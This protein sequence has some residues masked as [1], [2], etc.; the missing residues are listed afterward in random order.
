MKIIFSN[1]RNISKKNIKKIDDILK[2]EEKQHQQIVKKQIKKGGAIDDDIC[3]S[4]LRPNEE[5]KRLAYTFLEHI[6]QI[7]INKIGHDAPQGEGS[8]TATL[9]LETG[10]VIGTFHVR[11]VLDGYRNPKLILCVYDIDGNDLI[12]I[13]SFV[14]SYIHITIDNNRIYYLH[15]PE[16]Q[17]GWNCL[18]QIVT[19]IKNY[20]ETNPSYFNGD[21]QWSFLIRNLGMRNIINRIELLLQSLITLENTFNP[22]IPISTTSVPKSLSSKKRKLEDSSSKQPSPPRAQSRITSPPRPPIS[23][24]PS[25]LRTPIS[26]TKPSHPRTP[27]TSPPRPQSR[28]PISSRL[29]NKT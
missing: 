17:V 1:I 16:K 13:T 12:H 29:G 7:L 11:T 20:L 5:Q 22:K 27:I 28:T 4:H 15:N 18:I 10:E 14:E 25:H 24:K 6:H 19:R 23:T 26:T 21:P 9:K 8:F 3:L 2:I